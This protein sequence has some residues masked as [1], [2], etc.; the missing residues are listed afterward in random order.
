M[1]AEAKVV[2]EKRGSIPKNIEG[3]KGL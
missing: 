1:K 2:A 3:M